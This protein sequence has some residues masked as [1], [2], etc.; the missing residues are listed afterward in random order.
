MTFQSRGVAAPF[1]T[2]LLVATRVRQSRSRVIELVGPSPSGGRGVYVLNWSGVRA[3]CNPTVHDT[4]LFRRC[5][6]LGAI[7]PA[8]VRE[9]ALEVALAGHAGPGALAAAR[10]TMAQDRSR[11]LLAH[12][13]LVMELVEQLDPNGQRF[14]SIEQRTADLDRRAKAVLQRIAPSLGQHPTQLAAGLTAIG[15]AFA[16]IGVAS[17]DRN[18]RIPQLLARLEET[19]AELSRWLDADPTN[20][21][22]GLGR[23]IAD[24]MVGACDSCSAVLAKTR[25]M[26]VDPR[27]LLKR[28]M[29]DANGVRTAIARCEWLLDG[30]ERVSLLWLA[31]NSRASRRAALLE[32]AP[33]VPVLPREVMEWTDISIP[34]DAISQVCRVTSGQDDWRTGGSAFAL[35]ERNEKLLAMST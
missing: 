14:A 21:I 30:W 35:I 5:S 6:G 8:L 27:A 19:H 33:L 9:V 4:V 18:A 2:P 15:E 29:V 28:W 7:T 10:N 11:G 31:A 23:A 12:F 13:L 22:G 20:E 34:T 16:P 25:S 24:A 26:L 17:D 1:T 32:M 3:L